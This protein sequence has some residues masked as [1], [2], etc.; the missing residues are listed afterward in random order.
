[1]DNVLIWELSFRSTVYGITVLDAEGDYNVYINSN[2]SPEK[3]Q[4]ALEHELRHIQ[5]G[6]LYKCSTIEDDELEAT[7]PIPIQKEVLQKIIVNE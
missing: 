1:M 6:H 5:C 7:Q 4:K 2:L 3:K